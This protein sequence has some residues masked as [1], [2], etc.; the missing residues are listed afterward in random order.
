MRKIICNCFGSV[1]TFF[2][3][4]CVCLVALTMKIFGSGGEEPLMMFAMTALAADKKTEYREGV[5]ISIPV[6]DADVIYAGAMVS[7][8]ADGYAVAAGDTAS[9]LFVGI[10]REQ[11]DNSLGL[12]GAINVTVRRRGL[13]KMSFA[14]PI[15]IAN[16]GDSVYIADDQNVDL[17]GNVNN[18]VFAGIIAE[19]IDTTHAWVDIEPAIRQSDAAAH[20][21]D[22]SGAHAASAISVADAGQFTSQT[23]VEAALQEI[24][25]HLKSAKGIV[26]IPIPYFTDA[27]AA[28]AAFSNGDS[29]VPGYC[30]TAKGLGIRWNNHATPGA[31]GA[32]VIV[33]PDMDVTAN[34]VL[35]VL[36]AKTGATVG[37]ATKFTVAA[38]NNVVDA[39]FDA[40]ANFGGD[41]SAMTGDAAAKTVQ[42]ETLTLA[43]ANL[44]AYPAAVELTIKPKDGTLGTDDV[45]LLAAWIEYK[46][47]LLAA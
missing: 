23:E 14:T 13:F 32:K 25:Q 17:V 36:A 15:T 20:I 16:V 33:P 28:L 39:E 34:A 21:A 47:K 22:G 6:D 31:V 19:Y 5:D 7:V 4:F 1:T 41:T 29:T 42:H 40:D 44:A 8:N 38:Y 35:H 9:T 3:F 43:L 11:A 46:K 18:D 24:Y 12:D 45:I 37:D 30:V 2:M 10:A 27:G 26:D